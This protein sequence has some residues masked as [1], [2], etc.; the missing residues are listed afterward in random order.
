VHG[1]LTVDVRPSADGDVVVLAGEL[2]LATAEALRR[3]LLDVLG[4]STTVAVDAAGLD[5]VDL[6]GLDVLL[7][8]DTRLRADGGALVVRRASPPLRRL[9]GLLGDPLHVAR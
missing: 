5:F 9:L 4:T 3:R 8:L 1:A 7:D 6:T 2:D